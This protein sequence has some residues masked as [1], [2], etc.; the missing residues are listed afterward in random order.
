MTEKAAMKRG[1][2]V[3]LVDDETG[4]VK[5]S[6]LTI[7]EANPNLSRKRLRKRRHRLSMVISPPPR[8]STSQRVLRFHY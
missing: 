4:K 6:D 8:P 7:D 3:E 1:Y 2:R 5:I